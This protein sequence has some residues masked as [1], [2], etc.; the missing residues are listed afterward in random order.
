MFR[1]LLLGHHQTRKEY[2][3]KLIELYHNF[4]MDPYYVLTSFLQNFR[5][6]SQAV[7]AKINIKN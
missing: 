3:H 4:N 2:K 6:N 7:K 5:I 1:P